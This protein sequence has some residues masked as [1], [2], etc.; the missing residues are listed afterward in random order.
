M[1]FYDPADLGIED[2]VKRT[3]VGYQTREFI[4][5]PTGSA[6][7][8]RALTEYRKGIE[9]LQKMAM[10]EWRGSPDKELAEYRSLASDLATPLKILRWI[11]NVIA[12]GENAEK[13][14]KHRGSGEFEP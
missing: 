10:K 2:L 13:I 8:E 5:T 6:M 7:V 11:D 4:S 12:D 1:E 14:S 3:R 9:S